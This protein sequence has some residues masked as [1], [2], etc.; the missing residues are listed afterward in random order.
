MGGEM[1][2]GNEFYVEYIEGDEKEEDSNDTNQS[3]N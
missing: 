2:Q 1:F 3:G